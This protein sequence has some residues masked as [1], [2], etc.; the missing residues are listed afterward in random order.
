MKNYNQIRESIG[1]NLGLSKDEGFNLCQCL[2]QT[3]DIIGDV[4]EIGVF[5]GGSAILMERY[6]NKNKTLYLFDTF[7]GWVDVGIEDKGTTLVNGSGWYP[8]VEEVTKLFNGKSVEII[9]GFFPSSIPEGF[10]DKKFSLIHSDTD[11]YNSTLNTLK[12]FYDKVSVG[13]IIIIH[14]Y[15]N[16]NA[17]GVKKAVDL[18]FKDKEEKITSLIDTQ[19]TIIKL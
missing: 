13:G 9:N 4:V 11:T 12:Y 8:T 7:D 5:Q 2:L 14:D 17:P 15:I 19:V 6:K 10:S 16:L 1:I 3:S 18:F